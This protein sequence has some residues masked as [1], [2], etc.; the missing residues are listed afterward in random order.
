MVVYASVQSSLNELTTR[1]CAR[2][3][4]MFHDRLILGLSEV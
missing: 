2:F 4:K 1:V 3:F